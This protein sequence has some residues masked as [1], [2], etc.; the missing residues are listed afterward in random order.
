[1]GGEGFASRTDKFIGGKFWNAANPKDGFAIADCED[2]RAKRVLE[3][4]IPILHPEKPTWVTVTAGNTILVICWE[5]EKSIGD[6]TP[7]R[8]RQA[9]GGSPETQGY[10]YWALYVPP[11]YGIGGFE[12]GGDSSLRHRSGFA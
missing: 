11:L 9:R 2:S 10:T 1:M 5:R 3:F 6:C 7:S 12:H 8:R 4:F